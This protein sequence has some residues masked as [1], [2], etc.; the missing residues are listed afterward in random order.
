MSPTIAFKGDEIVSA[1]AA[2]GWTNSA[3]YYQT[4]FKDSCSSEWEF[5]K[6]WSSP[7]FVLRYRYNSIPYAPG[8]VVDI[9]GGIPKTT[10]SAL[11]RR[12]HKIDRRR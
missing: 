3:S 9:E 6:R 5:R 12:G 1:G 11:A 8:T 2:G 10:F 7:R 4:L